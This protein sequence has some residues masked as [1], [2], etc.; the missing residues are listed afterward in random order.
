MSSAGTSWAKP[1]FR[2]TSTPSR[3]AKA[4]LGHAKTAKTAKSAPVA[5]NRVDD[6]CL[7]QVSAMP[8]RLI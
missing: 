1:E 6:Q 8:D 7:R 2:P 3:C 5:A 4:R